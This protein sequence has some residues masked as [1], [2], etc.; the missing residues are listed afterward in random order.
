MRKV[1]LL[2]QLLLSFCMYSAREKE[3]PGRDEDWPNYGGNKAGNRYSPLDQIN[4]GNVQ[5][6]QVAWMYDASEKPNPANPGRQRNRAIQCQPI[7]VNGIMYGTTPELKLFALKAESGEQLWKFEPGKN[8]KLNSNRGVVYWRSGSDQRILYTVGSGL[9]AVNAETGQIIKSFGVEG[10]VDIHEGLSTNMDHD[11]SVLSVNATSPGIIHKNTF[12]LGSAVSESGDAAPGHIRAFD[13]VTGRLKWVFHTIP[14]PGEF[15][16]ET[17]PKGAY[18]KIGAANNWSGMSVDEKRG[19]VYFGTGS[20]ASDFY[21]GDRKGANLFAN[22]ILALD[23][24]TG[25]MKWY[26]QTI[27]HDLWDRDHP[28][29]PNLTTIKHNGKKVDVLVQSTKDGLVYVLDRDKGT[30]I[31]PVKE[32]AV[33]TEGLPGEHPYPTQ[34]YPVKPLPL[35]R[36]IFTENDITDLSPESHAY[37]K[38]RYQKIKTNNK[39]A[40]PSTTGTL[41]FGYSGGAEWGGNAVDPEG[42]FYQ[43]ANEE[44][45]ELIMMDAAQKKTDAPRTL[46]NALYMT[47]CSACH[48]QDRKGSGNELPSLVD[49]GKK[50]NTASIQSILKTGSGRM[51]AFSH[52]SEKEQDAIISFLFNIEKDQ[53]MVVETKTK[54]VEK[55]AFP[56]K[57]AYVTK[58]WQRFTDQNGYPAVK[59]PWGTLNA[60]DLNTGEYLWRVPLGEYPELAKKGIPTTGTDSYGGPLVTAGGLVFIAGTKD[61]KIRA[62]DKR[63]GKVV[64]EYQLPAGGFAT[65]ITYQINGK[66]Y[67]AIAA[68]GGRGQ[69][70][71]GNYIAFSLK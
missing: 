32:R 45:W 48:G 62:F 24:E 41:L 12:I 2:G 42:V 35:S 63:T 28:S 5:A 66:Q 65:P 33:P 51:P 49:I 22:C 29:P 3:K 30:S 53:K 55:N 17:W 34:K 37:V 31:F 6:L 13:V 21:G 36:Q 11:V 18:K 8:D 70:I 27:H 7:V 67:V 64:W 61:E 14:Q 69:K 40:P 23:A 15:G 58:S 25:K 71:G 60:I 47:N 9:Y 68:G 10:R 39:F 50:L 54:P 19:V 46:G 20:P 56:Y 52:L 43:N 1:I 16:Y 57:P 59:P 38:E 4:T 26:Y 44:P